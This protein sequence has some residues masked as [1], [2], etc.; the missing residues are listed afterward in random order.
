M[1]CPP[2]PSTMPYRPWRLISASIAA[3]MSV[4]RPR[5]DAAPRAAAAIPAHIASSAASAI[6]SNSGFTSPTP[7]VMAASPC[8]PSTIAPQSSEMRSPSASTAACDG[9]ACTTC[10][11]TDEQI[12]AGNPWYPLND[13]TAPAARIVSSAIASR[14]AVLTPGATAVRIFSSAALTTR[15]AARIFTSWSTL[16]YWM[17]RLLLRTLPTV[18]AQ[19]VDRPLRDVFDKSG[20]VDADKL[21]LRAVEVDQRRGFRGVL[22]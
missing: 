15:P 3:E 7:T 9:M 8:H 5:P 11:F 16:L 1:P 2:Y 19:G 18:R 4:S 20:G 10:S 14:S 17:S 12:V 6:R 21:S 22:A 13:G